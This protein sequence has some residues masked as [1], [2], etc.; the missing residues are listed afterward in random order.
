MSSG[1]MA[2]VGLA[3]AIKEVLQS[4]GFDDVDGFELFPEFS[5]RKTLLSEPDDIGLGQINEQPALML[6]E[7][8]SSLSEFQQEFGIWGQFFHGK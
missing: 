1:V 4:V 3:K 5:M 7:R 6:A 8:H 2:V